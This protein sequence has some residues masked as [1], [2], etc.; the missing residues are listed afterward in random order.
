MVQLFHTW[1][2]R[3]VLPNPTCQADRLPT[4][5]EY[6]QRYAINMAYMPPPAPTDSCHTFKRRIYATLLQLTMKENPDCEMRIIRKYPAVDWNRIWCNLHTSGL[7]SFIKS[8]WNAAINDILSTH[9][10]LAEIHLVPTNACPRC[11][12]PDSVIHRV[13]YCGDGPLQCTW[14]KQ[15]LGFILRMDP[16]HIPKEWMIYSALHL[17]P[18]QR[19]SAALWIL[20]HFVFCSVQSTGH[21]SLRDYMDFMKRAKWKLQ[22]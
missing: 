20:V 17:W 12:N 19:H 10:R 22:Q 18:P 7:S 11:N 1:A 4:H 8:T 5:F 14:T 2:L 13:T 21:L 6:L 16:K 3:N 9:D 15:K